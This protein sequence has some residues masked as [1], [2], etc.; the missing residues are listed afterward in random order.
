MSGLQ[1]FKG[2]L[3]THTTE[4]DGDTAPEHV[5]EWYHRHG[6]DFLVLS[7]HNH[8]TILEG[9]AAGQAEWPLLIP[10]EEVSA[11]FEDRPI[12]V[13]GIGLDRLVEP[14]SGD[15][16]SDTIQRNVDAVRAAGGLAAINHPNYRWAFDDR[17]IVPVSGAWAMEVYNGHHLTNSRGGGGRPG[18]EVIWDRVLSAGV[19]VFGIATDDAHHFQDEF[20]PRRSNP[21]RGWVGVAAEEL[22][23][24]AM[25]EAMAAG[26]FYSSTGVTLAE[27][28]V[29]EREIVIEIEPEEQFTYTTVFSG[30]RGREVWVAEG[31][32][33]HYTLSRLDSYVRATV[34]ASNGENA[35]T[36][37]VFSER[38]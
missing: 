36:Q 8:L 33:A 30:P 1:W 13:G 4:S 24:Q 23:G 18:A 19:Q 15:S 31:L 10:G 29:G 25:L 17:G 37:P 38:P 16:V 2:N 20:G 21:G 22:S 14:E 27:L 26:R 3:H 35:W 9:G 12:H 32:S 28:N 6:Y 11:V 34:H 5:A 7:D